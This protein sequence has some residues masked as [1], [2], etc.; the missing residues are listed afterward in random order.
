MSLIFSLTQEI[1]DYTIDHE[2]LIVKLENNYIWG[3]CYDLINN[4]FSILNNA[5]NSKLFTLAIAKLNMVFNNTLTQ[6]RFI[7]MTIFKEP[8]VKLFSCIS[9]TCVF[10]N[11]G[12]SSDEYKP[13]LEPG[14][15]NLRSMHPPYYSPQL[16]NQ[17]FPFPVKIISRLIHGHIS[18]VEKD[19]L[20]SGKDLLWYCRGVKYV[21][22]EY[23]YLSTVD[24]TQLQQGMHW[25]LTYVFPSFC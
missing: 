20:F 19:P 5:Q 12:I 8:H 18:F 17:V 6:L 15:I 24:L 16:R 3:P 4:Y 13:S 22:R 9:L 23:V 21:L 1:F 2:K 11:T 10:L 14:T 7:K 25:S